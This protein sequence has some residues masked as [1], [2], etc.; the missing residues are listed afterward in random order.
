MILEIS[1][2]ILKKLFSNYHNTSFSQNTQ[3]YFL[4]Y[5]SK[6]V[7][8]AKYAFPKTFDWGIKMI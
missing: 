8:F 4:N 5:L 3:F 2:L 6:S 1:S 7:F